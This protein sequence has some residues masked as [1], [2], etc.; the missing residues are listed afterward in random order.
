METHNTHA[1]PKTKKP[2]FRLSLVRKT[3]NGDQWADIGVGWSHK[4][5]DGI[6]FTSGLLELFGF[7]IIVRSIKGND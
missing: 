6:S 7:K 1:Q 4:D 3:V 2:D 5:G